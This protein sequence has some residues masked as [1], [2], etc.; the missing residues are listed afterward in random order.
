MIAKSTILIAIGV[1][2]GISKTWYSQII[3]NSIYWKSHLHITN[4]MHAAYIQKLKGI[5]M[6]QLNQ[7]FNWVQQP[8]LMQSKSKKFKTSFS[9]FRFHE[10]SQSPSWNSSLTPRLFLSLK[11]SPEQR[12]QQKGADLQLKLLVQGTS[13]G[14][15]V[16]TMSRHEVQK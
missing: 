16:S 8:T 3:S 1:P 10:W 11:G 2:I 12:I 13:S 4:I 7:R 6:T 14:P 9:H 15:H 5:W